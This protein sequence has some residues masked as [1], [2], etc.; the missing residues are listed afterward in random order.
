MS[1][2]KLYEDEV[3]RL[4]DQVLQ[5]RIDQQRTLLQAKQAKLELADRY[6]GQLKT[7]RGCLG[8]VLGKS[9]LKQDQ[10]PH[11]L[12]EKLQLELSSLDLSQELH[13]ALRRYQ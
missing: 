7:M 10:V 3:T 9:G 13:S 12:K 1:N 6:Q 2:V 8:F 5:A 11:F 4:R